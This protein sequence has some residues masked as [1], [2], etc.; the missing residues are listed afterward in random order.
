MCVLL[1]SVIVSLKV[2]L[3]WWT[4]FL[5]LSLLFQYIQV[6]IS[7]PNALPARFEKLVS[8][9]FSACIFYFFW[10]C[11]NP[12]SCAG[13]A[14]RLP[15]NPTVLLF[16]HICTGTAHYHLKEPFSHCWLVQWSV[17]RSFSIY[18][19]CMELHSKTALQFLNNWSRWGLQLNKGLNNWFS[20]QIGIWEFLNMSFS[21]SSSSLTVTRNVL[22]TKKHHCLP[23][24]WRIDNE[25][26]CW[27]KLVPAWHLLDSSLWELTQAA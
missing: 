21:K 3:V 14:V 11:A 15:P 26:K 12:V 10:C 25:L 17:R 16:H 8:L 19:T 22:L 7:Q 18:D 24:K 27:V 4:P 2:C 9:C 23:S 6:C 5:S 13:Q 20:N 1:Q